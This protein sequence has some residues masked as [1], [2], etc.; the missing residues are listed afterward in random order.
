MLDVISVFLNDWNLG[1]PGGPVVMPMEWDTGSIPCLGDSHAEGQLSLCAT[2]TEPALEPVS[3][4]E[5]SPRLEPVFFNK[6]NQCN[7]NP[8]FQN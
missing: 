3:H 4:N 5:L 1:F 2:A 7:E 6:R 8:S